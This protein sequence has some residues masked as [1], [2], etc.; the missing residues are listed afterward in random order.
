MDNLLAAD[1]FGSGINDMERI[2]LMKP[3][4][5]KLDRELISGIDHDPAKQTNVTRIVFDLHS[6]NMLVVAEG[7]EEKS[8]TKIKICFLFSVLYGCG[9]VFLICRISIRFDKMYC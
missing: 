2:D 1:D 5:V 6:G 8:Y 3:D 7:V 4:L 9:S